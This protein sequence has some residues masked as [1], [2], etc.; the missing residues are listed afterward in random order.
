M[1]AL[2]TKQATAWRN[3][4]RHNGSEIAGS[5]KTGDNQ[6]AHFHP[7]TAPP[8]TRK[9]VHRRKVSRRFPPLRPPL[10]WLAKLMMRNC[11]NVRGGNQLNYLAKIAFTTA[12]TEQK[13]RNDLLDNGGTPLR[14]C[15]FGM[16][17]VTKSPPVAD[18]PPLSREQ[19]PQQP[20]CQPE[21]ARLSCVS[22]CAAVQDKRPVV[23][24]VH[25]QHRRKRGRRRSGPKPR[26]PHFTPVG[27]RFFALLY[28]PP[29]RHRITGATPRSPN[30]IQRA[31]PS[32]NHFPASRRKWRSPINQPPPLTF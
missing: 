6:N 14:F 15:D 12:A 17:L 26:P 20:T 7:K 10:P 30:P 28:S 31:T 5:S 21:P 8:K 13:R 23:E 18:F 4:A 24:T 9:E 29:Y 19:L 25:P 22:L 11:F 32:D 3:T 2:L 16:D 27:G 1:F